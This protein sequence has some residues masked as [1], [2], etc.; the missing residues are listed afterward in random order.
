[1]ADLAAAQDYLRAHALDAWLVYDFHA[2]NP[3]FGELVPT[4]A[5]GTRRAWLLVPAHGA[6]RLLVHHVD[7]GRFAAAGYAVETYRSYQEHERALAAWLATHPRVAMEYVPRGD[8]PALARVDAGTLELVRALGGQPS[9][10]AE[11]YQY[12]VARWSAAALASHRF[13]ATVLVAAVHETFRFLGERLRAGVREGEAAGF[14]RQRL[15][16]AGL[17]CTEGPIV[18]FDAHTG[19]PHYEPPSG[20]GAAL[21]RG[22]WV[23]IDVWAKRPDPE[24]V[25]ADVTWMGSVGEPPAERAAAFAAVCGARDAAVATLERAYAAGQPVAGWELDR[26]ARAYLA[27]RGRAEAFTHRLGHSLGVDVHGRGANL[28]DFETHD[29]R[30]LIPGLGFTIEPGLY[31][32]TFGVRSEINIYLGERGPEVTTAV[33]RELVRVGDQ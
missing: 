22:S 15:E 31:Y 27:E 33:Q 29:T 25:Y 18:A 21:G 20:G 4:A 24:A 17:V 2:S 13:A 1:M 32:A 9:S 3:V 8:L 19:D 11:L 6:P 23:L 30:P 16:A 7:A 5:P 12:A 14:L 26:A 28:D 10:S